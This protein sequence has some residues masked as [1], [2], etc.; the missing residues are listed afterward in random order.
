[1][2]ICRSFL[3][4][5]GFRG[6]LRPG[7]EAAAPAPPHWKYAALP[8]RLTPEDIA[9][10]LAGYHEGTAISLR[11]RAMRFLLARLGRRAPDGVSLSGDTIHWAEGRLDLPPGKSRRARP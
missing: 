3:R 7:F 6:A 1:V 5:L 2:P 10:G 8:S 9:R 4:W 11:N